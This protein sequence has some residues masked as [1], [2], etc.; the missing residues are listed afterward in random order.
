VRPFVTWREAVR[1]G[2]VSGSIASV[3][4]S[5]AL[6]VCGKREGSTAMGPINGPSQWAWGERAARVR[7]VT[8]RHTALGYA[9]HHLMSIG[10][11]TLHE[12][13]L[14][15][16]ANDAN[17]RSRLATGALTAATAAFVDYR[18][19]PRRFGPGFEKQ[20]GRVSLVAVYAA[21][22][23]GL[24]LGRSAGRGRP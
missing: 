13:H 9:I 18:V 21:F 24:A 20:L 4:S 7:R 3:L 17:L 16:P 12:K 11:A 22:A 1:R 6:A 19:V 5:L 14:A 10:W 23:L 8:W 15:R 2:V